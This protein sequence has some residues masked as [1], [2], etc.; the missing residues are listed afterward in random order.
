MRRQPTLR[1]WVLLTAFVILGVFALRYGTA[2][3]NSVLLAIVGVLCTGV[4][5]VATAA[6]PEVTREPIPPGQPGTTAS[7]HYQIESSSSYPVTIY[8][9]LPD[10]LAGIEASEL[11]ATDSQHR[12]DIS[13]EQWGRYELPPIQVTL[14]DIFGL[15][16]STTVQ[17]EKTEVIVY[18]PS[19]PVSGTVLTELANLTTESGTTASQTGEFESLR[20]Y[21]PGDPLRDI[22]WKA[23]AR[24]GELITQRQQGSRQSPV[25]T[26][27]I[28]IEQSVFANTGV[29]HERTA[30]EVAASVITATCDE[31]VTVQLSI[32]DKTRT[33]SSHDPVPL[34]A[35]LARLPANE[36][37]GEFNERE[38]ASDI[39]ISGGSSGLT[40]SIGSESFVPTTF[41]AQQG[42]SDPDVRKM[43]G[44][45]QQVPTPSQ[46]SPI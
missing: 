31:R 33:A 3:L 38:P 4:I 12:F 26:L 11:L 35:E 19:K 42:E 29:Q 44:V 8:Q 16:A 21:V 22:H 9:A 15:F 40:I 46:G 5:Q 13:R 32:G 30:A 39:I 45:D 10:G 34:L 17:E 25:T 6:P 1:G 37:G 27:S 24:H 43:I 14:Y 23:A 7:V 2:A 36:S 41:F 20:E 18:P 28:L